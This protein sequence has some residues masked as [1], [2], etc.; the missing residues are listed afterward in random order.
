MDE[1]AE[2][3]VADHG[4]A[5]L[6]DLAFAEV[7]AQIVEERT[8]NVLV[9]DEEPLGEVERRLFG[10]TEVLVRPRPDLADCLLFQGFPS[11]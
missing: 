9:V 3:E 1:S 10:R 7:P 4:P 8:V 5:E 11:P 6:D 2:P